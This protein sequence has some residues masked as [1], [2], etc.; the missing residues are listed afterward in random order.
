MEGGA[1][2]L[3]LKD[4]DIL[5]NGDLNEGILVLISLQLSLCCKFILHDMLFS[6]L[7]LVVPD[8]DMLENVEIGEQKRRS[9]AYQ[10]AKK[11][12]GIYD[13]K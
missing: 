7:L 1:V 8:M 3:T 9:E 11:S 4:Q 12:T 5:A 2:V 13:D 6:Y 10:A